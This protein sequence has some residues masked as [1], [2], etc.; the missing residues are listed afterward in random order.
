[1][2]VLG[3]GTIFQN[4]RFEGKVGDYGGKI[5]DGVI[6]KLDGKVEIFAGLDEGSLEGAA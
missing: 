6:G 1:M 5:N 2:W 3:F 4:G